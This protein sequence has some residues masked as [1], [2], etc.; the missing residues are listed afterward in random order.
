MLELVLQGL[1][2]VPHAT[3]R[4]WLQ[5]L[6]SDAVEVWMHH[7]LLHSDSLLGIKQQHAIQEVYL[8][9]TNGERVGWHKC[10]S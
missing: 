4:V 1:G 6:G 10:V 3:H 5:V 8:T 2:S 9:A 7:S